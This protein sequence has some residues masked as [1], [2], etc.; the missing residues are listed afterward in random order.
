M[1]KG[2]YLIG[3]GAFFFNEND[4]VEYVRESDDPAVA[5]VWGGANNAYLPAL[6]SAMFFIGEI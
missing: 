3:P 4:I 1:E 2:I 5:W 6:K